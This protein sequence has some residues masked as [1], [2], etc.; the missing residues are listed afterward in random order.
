LQLDSE[1]PLC[2]LSSLI[3]QL[4]IRCFAPPLQKYS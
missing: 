4:P 1:G 2:D 3:A